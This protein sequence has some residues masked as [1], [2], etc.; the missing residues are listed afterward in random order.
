MV[1]KQKGEWESPRESERL[2]KG[3]WRLIF[4]VGMRLFS[5]PQSLAPGEF[6]LSEPRQLRLDFRGVALRLALVMKSPT[7]P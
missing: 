4:R 7:L 3:F 5:D 2:A 1:L 6:G